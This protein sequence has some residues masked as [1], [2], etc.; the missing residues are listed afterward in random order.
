MGGF[1]LQPDGVSFCANAFGLMDSHS[2]CQ[3]LLIELLEVLQLV[4]EVVWRLRCCFFLLH[5]NVWSMGYL[6]ARACYF[7]LENSGR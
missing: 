6:S 7:L 1:W 4:N 5:E 2:K 3:E